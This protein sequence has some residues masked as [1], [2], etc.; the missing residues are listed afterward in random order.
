M[1]AYLN[2]TISLVTGN[3]TGAT[4]AGG[5]FDAA[6]ALTDRQLH[7]AAADNSPLQI[8][9]KAK[10][11]VNDIFG[12]IEEYVVETARFIDG[13]YSLVFLLVFLL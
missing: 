5:S 3:G 4:T 12:E 2:R 13:E 8:F 6:N 9:V 11:R 7:N 1:A 10:K